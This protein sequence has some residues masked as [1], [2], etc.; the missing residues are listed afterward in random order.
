MDAS[1]TAGSSSASTRLTLPALAA[2]TASG[3]EY[4]GCFAND[5]QPITLPSDLAHVTTQSS[6]W[7]LGDGDKAIGGTG[8]V[9]PA[10]TAT[11]AGAGDWIGLAAT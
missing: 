5:S 7:Q 4:V 1:A 6:Q 2:T 8:S 3:D 10:E 9:P 11:S